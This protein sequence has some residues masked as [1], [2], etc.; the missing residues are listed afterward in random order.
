MKA[1]S[2]IDLGCGEGLLETELR[3]KAILREISSYDL[4]STKEHIKACDI[5]KLPHKSNSV[6]IAVFC[7]S[8]MG[9]NYLEFLAEAIRV[10]RVHGWLIISEVSSRLV[11]QKGFKDMLD[12]I[13]LKMHYFVSLK[14]LTF[15]DF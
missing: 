6:D 4:I 10:L 12:Q 1:T 13:G 2:L 5:R 3:K 11:S 9:T 8:L 7:L 15:T 14:F